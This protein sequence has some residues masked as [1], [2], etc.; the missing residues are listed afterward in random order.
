MNGVNAVEKPGSER[1]K[2]FSACDVTVA[3]CP[4]TP[5]HDMDCAAALALLHEMRLKNGPSDGAGTTS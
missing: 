3:R 4:W 1:M 5:H 2:S